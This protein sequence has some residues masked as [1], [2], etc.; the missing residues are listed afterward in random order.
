MIRPITVICW[1]LAL[2]AGLYLYRAKH[3]VELMDKHID[4][5][6][7]Q[8]SDL[9]AESRRLLDDWIRLGE[10]EQLHKYSDEY[11]GLKTIAPTQFARLSDLA[12]RLPAPQTDPPDTQ[13]D[14]VAQSSDPAAGVPVPGAS[15]AEGKSSDGPASGV[16]TAGVHPSTADAGGGDADQV[17]AAGDEDLPLPPIPPATVPTEVAVTLPTVTAPPLQAK[18]VTP[19]PAAGQPELDAARARAIAAAR[20][21]EQKAARPAPVMLA[22]PRRAPAQDE[23]APGQPAWQ[24]R[25]VVPAREELPL[26]AQGLAPQTQGLPPLQAQGLPRLRAPGYSPL[27]APGPGQPVS[28]GFARVSAPATFQAPGQVF[29]QGQTR[30]AGQG[31]MQS[32]AQAPPQGRSLT[33]GPPVGQPAY[34]PPAPRIAEIRA[35]EPQRDARPMQTQPMD[36]RVLGNQSARES[37]PP[38]M[39][40]GPSGGGSLLGGSR[41]PVPLPLPAPTPVSA[42]WSGSG[43]I[44][45]SR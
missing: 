44:G 30:G 34:R 36:P 11:L 40:P 26:Q 3:E 7:K 32:D 39:T 8:T 24:A 25:A 19:R 9:R 31:P 43:P 1:I 10:P 42:T 14:V 35:N 41:G 13:P 28:S 45:P 22:D 12:N 27:R 17:N 33:F 4:K 5:I 2:G 29:P 20:A 38:Q 6:A 37:P 21:D 16:S 18:P 15:S 23:T